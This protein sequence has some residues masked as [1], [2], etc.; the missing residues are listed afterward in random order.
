MEVMVEALVSRQSEVES[1]FISLLLSID[2]LRHPLLQG[3]SC[4]LGSL[5]AGYLAAN[6]PELHSQILK[7][8]CR[9]L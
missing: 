8:A 4:D 7:S 3:I 6:F 2:G 1:E 9:G 5:D